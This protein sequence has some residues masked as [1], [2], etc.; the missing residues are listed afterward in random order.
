M[1]PKP[2]TGDTGLVLVRQLAALEYQGEELVVDGQ[3]VA[4]FRREL[5]VET[6]LIR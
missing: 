4:S 1:A 6:L 5:Q 3:Q 2:Q